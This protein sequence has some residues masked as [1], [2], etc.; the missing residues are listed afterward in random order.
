MKIGSK[1]KFVKSLNGFKCDL[2]GTVVAQ[3]GLDSV[4]VKTLAGHDWVIKKKNL[5]VMRS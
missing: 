1:V 3:Y 4:I 5:K 2:K